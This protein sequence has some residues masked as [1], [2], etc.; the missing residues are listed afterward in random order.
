MLTAPERLSAAH[1]LD[2]M[3]TP[4]VEPP[5]TLPATVPDASLASP[6]RRLAAYGIDRV[7]GM[8]VWLLG[9]VTGYVLAGVMGFRWEETRSVLRS[10]LVVAGLFAAAFTLLFSFG[11]LVL[12]I[13][14][15]Q[16]P[17][18]LVVG[19]RIVKLN[20]HRLE[21]WRVLLREVVVKAWVYGPPRWAMR[22]M[23]APFLPLSVA[24]YAISAI[25]D[26]A[27]FA[28]LV[29][30]SRRQ[31]F[32]DKVAKTLVVDARYRRLGQT[33]GEVAAPKVS[34]WKIWAGFGLVFGL[35][36]AGNL[37]YVKIK[38]LAFSVL[39]LEEGSSWGL[40][41]V[42]KGLAS[43]T[44]WISEAADENRAA[45]TALMLGIA[46]IVGVVLWLRRRR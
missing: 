31:T 23:L 22:W 34:R 9:G 24:G 25:R 35:V 5:E 13:L 26:S 7:L 33:S 14:R 46:V 30:D 32:H 2:K 29:R 6:A 28:W 17:G 43:F 16:S 42:L 27:L 37:A 39:Q 10:E 3:T 20:G 15:G 12:V 38:N 19:I 41:E 36:L 40:R 45:V 18:K 1:P 4:T 11:S 44:E 21:P 8:A